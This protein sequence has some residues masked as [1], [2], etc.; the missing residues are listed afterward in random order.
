MNKPNTLAFWY[1]WIHPPALVSQTSPKLQSGRGEY[2]LFSLPD[3]RY[4][5][6]MLARV[7]LYLADERLWAFFWRRC[8][9]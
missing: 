9:A 7:T 6:I 1:T 8:V 4:H 2:A 3:L 5:T